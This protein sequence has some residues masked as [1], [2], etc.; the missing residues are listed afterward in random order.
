MP[1]VNASGLILYKVKLNKNFARSDEMKLHKSLLSIKGRTCNLTPL[2]LYTKKTTFLWKIIIRADV[3]CKIGLWLL[4]SALPL[5]NIYTCTTFIFNPFC[6]YQDMAQTGIHYKTKW[7]SGDNSVNIHGRSMVLVHYISP[8]CHLSKTK[9]HFN[10]F[11]T[12]QAKWLSG[13]NSVNIHDRIRVLVHSNLSINQA[14]FQFLS[15]LTR[16][17]PNS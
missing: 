3:K 2:N 7:L 16:Y 14:V 4:C 12:F 15:Y 10:P 9:F 13:Y 5:I 11:C 17:E 6:T 1:S 8:H